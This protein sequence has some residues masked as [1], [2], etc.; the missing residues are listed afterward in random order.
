MLQNGIWTN[1]GPGFPGGHFHTA[2]EFR[3]ELEES[4]F[5]DVGVRS[6]DF[7]SLVFEVLRPRHELIESADT[8]LQSLEETVAG[9]PIEEPLAN[10]S[11]HMLGT[12]K[13]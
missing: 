7:P 13:R 4:G 8:L 11:A 6:L 1:D 12:G 9:L 5:S 2:E 10:L 3:Q